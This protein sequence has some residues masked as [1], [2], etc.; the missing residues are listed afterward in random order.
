MVGLGLLLKAFGFGIIRPVKS[1]ISCSRE[2]GDVG[3]GLGAGTVSR[4]MALDSG[5]RIFHA[6]GLKASS[7]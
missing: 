5:L 7:G 1:R 2:T 6:S 4:I 3:W